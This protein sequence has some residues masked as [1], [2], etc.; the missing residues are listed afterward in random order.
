MKKLLNSLYVTSPE[1]YLSLDGEN[2]VI[3]ENRGHGPFYGTAR[4]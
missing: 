1:N 3:L 4:L 2:I